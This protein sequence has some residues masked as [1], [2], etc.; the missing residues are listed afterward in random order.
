MGKRFTRIRTT[1]LLN[2]THKENPD[3]GIGR[4]SLCEK[5]IDPEGEGFRLRWQSMN[6]TKD[7]TG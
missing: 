7:K 4:D 1:T 6:V 3:R 5:A 2:H